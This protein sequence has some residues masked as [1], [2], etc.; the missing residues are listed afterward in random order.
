M[1]VSSDKDGSASVVQLSSENSHFLFE[2]SVTFA[3][4]THTAYRI[5]VDNRGPG[6]PRNHWTR[7]RTYWQAMRISIQYVAAHKFVWNFIESTQ[8]FL[9]RQTHLNRNI[10]SSIRPYHLILNYNLLQS[11][12]LHLTDDS[13]VGQ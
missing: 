10:Y 9:Y 7:D 1:R 2:N 3:G 13:S 8:R 5:V 12:S 6:F 4:L 11:I